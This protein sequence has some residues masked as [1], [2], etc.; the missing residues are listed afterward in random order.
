[1]TLSTR[2]AVGVGVGVL[3]AAAAAAALNTLGG[4]D[5]G[6]G[7]PDIDRL[8]VDPRLVEEGDWV[9]FIAQ[10]SDP[11]GRRLKYRWD[12][13]DGENAEDAGSVDVASMTHRYR[14]D[15]TYQGTLRVDAEDG[16]AVEDRFTV[17]VENVAPEIRDVSRSGAAVEDSDI[18]FSAG[19]IDPG[20]DDELTY[21]WDFGDG[22]TAEGQNPAHAYEED[23]VYRVT[24]EVDDGDGGTD[25]RTITVIVGNGYAW[26]VTGDIQASEEGPMAG[27]MGVRGE[28][29]PREGRPGYCS[30]RLYFD[31][32]STG[33]SDPDVG[34][35]LSAMLRGGLSEETYPV[36]AVKTVPG[37]FYV[38]ADPWENQKRSPGHVF[39]WLGTGFRFDHGDG[40]PDS[41]VSR[42]GD[43]SIDYFDGTRVEG[44][45]GLALVELGPEF[46]QRVNERPLRY[47][48]LSGH[49][50]HQLSV[51]RFGESSVDYYDCIPD[52]TFAVDTHFPD[53]NDENIDPEDPELEVEFT[54]PYD[55]ATLNEETFRID[56]R[57]PGGG[58]GDGY[59]R[60]D[61]FVERVDDQTVRFTPA[62]D[63][64]DGVLYCV[65]VKA[66]EEGVRGL[67]GEVLKVRP[68][69]TGLREAADPESANRTFR[70]CLAGGRPFEEAYEWGFATMVVLAS[71]RV[72]LAQVATA[73]QGIE[74]VPDKPTV[75]RVFPVWEEKEAVHPDAQVRRFAAD[76]EV[77]VNGGAAYT[78]K[79]RIQVRRP[80][81]FDA[82]DRRLAR[83]S[84]NF[85]GWR[86][87]RGGSASVVGLVEPQEQNRSPAREFE[88]A[89][90]DVPVW[91]HSPRFRF[92]YY[93]LRIGRWATGVP[94]DERASGHLLA[95]RSQLITTQNFPVVSTTARGGRDFE[96]ALDEQMLAELQQVGGAL[97]DNL[98]VLLDLPGGYRGEA[99]AG[100]QAEALKM[101]VRIFADRVGPYTDANAL[102]ALV[103]TTWAGGGKSYYMPGVSDQ[104]HD[105][106]PYRTVHMG[107][108]SFAY[109]TSALTHEFGHAFGLR[110]EPGVATSDE[111][112]TLCANAPGV[113]AGIEGFRMARGGRRGWNKSSTDG[114]AEL[115]DRLYPLMFPCAKRATESFMRSDKYEK[116][117]GAIGAAIDGG[118]YEGRVTSRSGPAD[119][120]RLV[121]ASL[122]PS[123]FAGAG[124]GGG[125][126]RP[127]GSTTT[128]QASSD[129][130]ARP[131]ALLVSGLVKAD[132]TGAILAPVRRKERPDTEPMEASVAGGGF[133]FVAVA[134]DSDGRVLG[135]APLSVDVD[136]GDGAE[137]HY[138]SAVLPGSAGADRIVVRRDGAP[139]GERRGSRYPPRVVMGSPEASETWTEPTLLRWSGEDDDGDAVAYTVLYSPTGTFPW[140]VLAAL[141]RATELDIDPAGLEPGPQPVLRVIAT[142]GFHESEARLPLMP[143]AGL[144][145]VATWPDAA[146]TVPPS[147]DVVVFLGGEL[148]HQLAPG[149][150]GLSDAAG[151]AVAADVRPGP[152]RRSIVLN[153]VRPLE[154]GA[155]YRAWVGAQIEDRFGNALGEDFL[156]TFTVESEADAEA[157][158]VPLGGPGA[159]RAAESGASA[160]TEAEGAT[161]GPAW[162]HPAYL[163]E[164]EAG[165]LG[166]DG[167]RF[168]WGTVSGDLED[169][170]AGNE[171]DRTAVALST[172]R[173]E[174]G[175]ILS[176]FDARRLQ[177]AKRSVMITLGEA[178]RGPGSYPA[179][180]EYMLTANIFDVYSGTVDF[181]VLVLRTPGAAGGPRLIAEVRGDGLRA[182]G[183]K[184]A[185]L[186]LRLDLNAA[187]EG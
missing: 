52:E 168:L 113:Q 109:V 112:A 133:A 77:K 13:G 2:A 45:F 53:R 71:V 137:W 55:P 4:P 23:G 105:V 33:G 43:L 89:T 6:S 80:D 22:N 24:V 98:A 11:D 39:G 167:V 181:E 84:I 117:Q 100:A 38:A 107:N 149:L 184:T 142:D 97:W 161:E 145:V 104:G 10:A 156:W 114:N 73:A 123:P 96:I 164:E 44:S 92:D 16:E 140:R 186:H 152:D 136:A 56:Y 58:G 64:L 169:E 90:Y 41:F 26:E 108:Q 118:T 74:L 17:V 5:P 75:A 127:R 141:T 182:E 185:D 7:P 130:S 49:F 40:R 134:E 151:Q 61:G 32:T 129:G 83:N 65:R 59:E 87:G 54:A 20:P 81:Q 76:V 1:M 29:L 183:G 120:R 110:H 131:G 153:P 157:Q 14:D 94:A 88:S 47:A 50:A 139:I 95:R 147:T 51:G 171:K 121:A 69:P 78:P 62:Y 3:A 132:G 146:S 172:C 170:F 125:L 158:S 159:P 60:L 119:G 28:T 124:S 19:A 66:G 36:G 57:L 9:D 68:A 126:L 165:T 70:A 85:F 63:L 8:D 101:L 103:P 46:A 163:T 67:D 174:G 166:A 116:L 25:S 15:G 138:F 187:C 128:R 154:P 122:F 18:T 111:R 176:L 91:R 12:F 86:P 21:E 135:E 34:I 93:F 35:H 143:R 148:T 179:F 175:M 27:V 144:R 160:T 178:L 106:F 82:E 99:Q 79:R 31:E 115:R 37:F 48:H 150:V 180:A 72:E 173:D 42:G 102:V 162:D 30:L 155:Q 177:D